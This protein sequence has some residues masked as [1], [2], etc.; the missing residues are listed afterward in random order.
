MGV[1]ARR[2]NAHAVVVNDGGVISLF[3]H[4]GSVPTKSRQ[5]TM[6]DL[7]IE[8]AVGDLGKKRHI[9]LVDFRHDGSYAMKS[10]LIDQDDGDGCVWYSDEDGNR[11]HSESHQMVA[12]NFFPDHPFLGLYCFLEPQLIPVSDLPSV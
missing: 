10:I 6:E 9:T 11:V 5:L 2:L 3:S 8:M 7:R 4:E 12:E 1:V